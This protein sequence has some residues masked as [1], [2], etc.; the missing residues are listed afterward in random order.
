MA[1]T[2]IGM[3]N[4]TTN[5]QKAQEELVSAGFDRNH[6]DIAEG[7]M[8]RHTG[9]YDGDGDVDTSDKV[10]SFFGN[11]FDNDDDVNRYSTAAGSNTVVTVY[12]NEMS[13]AKKAAAIMNQHG[14]LG[15]Q[16]NLSPME[17]YNDDRYTEAGY[18]GLGYTDTDFETTNNMNAD[19]SVAVVEE[20]MKVGKRE[21]TTGGLRV[22]SR[23]VEKPVQESLRLRTEEVYVDRKSVD[24]PAT[25]AELSG[26]KEGTIEMT[27][28]SEEAVVSKEARVKEEISLH[29]EVNQR[30]EVISDTVRST[31]VDVENISTNEADTTER[32]Y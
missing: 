25:E 27:E 7:S 18:A 8:T 30:E 9:D 12:T 17:S 31:E 16:N 29:K 28:R 14:A 21:V 22:H 11:L 20:N 4:A 13:Q 10:K 32:N 6:I 5:A 15:G 2:V 23:I 26:F 19:D 1:Q 24:R 3:F